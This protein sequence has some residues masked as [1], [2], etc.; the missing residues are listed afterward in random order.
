ME[1]LLLHFCVFRCNVGGHVTSLLQV[2]MAIFVLT[3]QGMEL[4]FEVMKD[5]NKIAKSFKP[6]S[7]STWGSHRAGLYENCDFFAH[8]A[9]Q[10]KFLQIVSKF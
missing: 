1:T 5:K 8:H 2:K 7:S 6:L 9:V 4:L 10:R 3:E